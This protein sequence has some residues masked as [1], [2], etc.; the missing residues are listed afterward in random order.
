MPKIASTHS[1][2]PGGEVSAPDDITSPSYGH[3]KFGPYFDFYKKVSKFHVV[4]HRQNLESRGALGCRNSG[5][6]LMRFHMF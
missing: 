4:E 2:L 3:F 1:Q 6:P 5:R